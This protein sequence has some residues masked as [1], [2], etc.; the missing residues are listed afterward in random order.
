MAVKKLTTEKIL[1]WI[2]VIGGFLGLIAAFVLTM[3]K[4]SLLQDPNFQPVCNI[5]PV[6]SCGSII[7]TEQASAF[8]FPNPFIGLAGFSVII[9]TGMALF[10]GAKFKRWYWLGLQAGT[11][12]GI[13][14][15]HWLIYQSLYTIGA[16]CMF[17]M[18]VWAVVWP[19]FWYTTL[20]NL[21]HGHLTTPPRLQTVVSFMQKHHLDIL[22]A[23][24]VLIIALILQNFWYYWS[25]LI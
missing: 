7:K 2:L 17:C 6:L 8:G 21:K 18:L 14:F 12:F 11:V 3:E 9:T 5:N 13:G 16:L 25:T 22:I 23:W 20:H 10:A 4:M 1:P 19:I 24:Y 15:A